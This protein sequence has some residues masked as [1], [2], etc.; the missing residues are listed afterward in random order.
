MVLL[1]IIL[2]V[3]RNR[4]HVEETLRICYP[5]RT[6]IFA[7]QLLKLFNKGAWLFWEEGKLVCIIC[8]RS[9]IFKHP[10]FWTTRPSSG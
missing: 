4:G 1:T 2:F 6:L 9:Q 8:S 7:P 5:Y 10:T 3:E